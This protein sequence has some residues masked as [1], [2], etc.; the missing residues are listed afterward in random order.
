M[1]GG[2]AFLLQN[3][4]GSSSAA[5]DVTPASVQATEANGTPDAGLGALDHQAP[6]IGQPAPDFVLRD[7]NG[8]TMKLSDLRGK[9]VYVNFWATWSCPA[10]RSCRTSRRSTRRSTL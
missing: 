3:T 6:V 4:R 8:K 2:G 10:S 7:I 9:V 5:P 1:L